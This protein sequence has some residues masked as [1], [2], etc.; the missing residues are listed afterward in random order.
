MA[1][2]LYG[3]GP[4]DITTDATG[5]V[6]GGVQMQVWTARTGGARVTDLRGTDGTQLPGVVTSA[7]TAGPDE[8]RVQ[9]Q[10]SDEYLVLWMDRGYGDRW[11]VVTSR[12]MELTQIAINTSSSAAATAA[13]AASDAT[14]ALEAVRDITV[15]VR[16]FGAKGDGVTDDAPA[17]QAAINSTP[18]GA[19]V[20]IPEGTYR[21]GS[22]LVLEEGT[23]L[24]ADPHARIVRAHSGYIA[25]NGIVGESTW[26]GHS[27]PGNI[28]ISGGIWDGNGVA[29]PSKSAIIHVAHSRNLTVERATFK[30]AAA[31]HHIEINSTDHATVRDCHFL[32]YVGPADDPINEAVQIDVA[33]EGALFVGAYDS[34]PC[35]DILID[36]CYFG[37]SGTPGSTTLMR[38][39]GSH[40]SVPESW[41]ERV[42]VSNCTFSQC[43]SYA[44]RFLNY[45][46]SRIVSNTIINCKQGIDWRA[47]FEA[48]GSSISD[49]GVISGN[50]LRGGMT[51]AEGIHLEGRTGWPVRGV[52]IIGNYIAVN[53]D[54]G[55]GISMSNAEG[56]AVVANTIVAGG[57]NG[58]GVYTSSTSVA[59]SQNSLLGI[60]GDKQPVGI[61]GGASNVTVVGNLITRTGTVTVGAV[62]ATSTCQ[63]VRITDNIA[64]GQTFSN[65]ATNSTVDA[66]GNII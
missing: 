16:A 55:A 13:S 60:R 10:A 52:Q 41:H 43:E 22:Q 49:G 21:I 26:G 54:S 11:Q 38:G 9:F 40:G 39:V 35:N 27:G 1:L 63:A 20:I 37:V 29:Y 6:V 45:R 64:R 3:G 47:A 59:V 46:D 50:Q 33:Q 44:I 32:G 14:A 36:H 30:D 17:F 56:I 42:T 4:A 61:S 66:N 24:D 12:L 2:T 65:G 25:C 53:P 51:A 19:H 5:Q 62:Y 34:T 58:I 23:W 15:N 8:G 18:L 48:P 57:G 28:R 31:S 7:T